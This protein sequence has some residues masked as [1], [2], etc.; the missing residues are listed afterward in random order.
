NG[1]EVC[2]A[3]VRGFEVRGDAVR[4][5]L[6]DGPTMSARTVVIAAGA[7]SRSLIR[8]LGFDVPLDTERGY[9]ATVTDPGISLRIPLVSMDYHLAVPPTTNGI[10]ICGTDELAGLH[11]PPNYARAE[12]LVKATRTIFPELRTERTQYWMKPRPS[13]PD[14]LP[15][16]GRAPNMSN[17]YVAF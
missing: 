16:I 15:V 1:G 12:R 14:S 5:V 17:V 9:G 4:G 8:Q 3:E 11:A 10:R 13:L 7:W 6:T 2:R